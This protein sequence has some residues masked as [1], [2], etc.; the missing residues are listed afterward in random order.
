MEYF[1]SAIGIFPV[2][3]VVELNTGEVGIVVKQ[4]PDRRL[5]PKV[6]LILDEQKLPLSE[7]AVIELGSQDDTPS[8]RT[9]WIVHELPKDSHGIDASQYFL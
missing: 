3:S 6:M 4:H 1:I 7:L 8:A 2:G 9:Q 5:R